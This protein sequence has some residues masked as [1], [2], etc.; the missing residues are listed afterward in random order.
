MLSIEVVEQSSDQLL[1]MLEQNKL[2]LIIGR[3]TDERYSQLFEF[4]AAGARAL[5]P[6]G[7]QS[8]IR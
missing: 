6:G 8:A 7:Q 5:L 3:F 2:D 1:E 4:R